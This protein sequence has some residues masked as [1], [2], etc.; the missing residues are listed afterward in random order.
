M[1]VCHLSLVSIL[2]DLRVALCQ[3]YMPWLQLPTKGLSQLEVNDA[4]EGNVH[5]YDIKVVSIIPQE[6]L[7]NSSQLCF[8][9]VDTEG[10]QYLLGGKD[11]PHPMVVQ[12]DRAS[13]RPADGSA[14]EHQILLRSPLPLLHWQNT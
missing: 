4:I 13:R 2:E 6:V 3:D 5:I 1:D 8:L 9:L 11:R 14:T 12:H 7:Y 10:N